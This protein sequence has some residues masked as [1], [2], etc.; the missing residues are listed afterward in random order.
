MSTRR[1][2]GH[3]TSTSSG[4]PSAAGFCWH[5]G[6]K[7]QEL[8]PGGGAVLTLQSRLHC[9]VSMSSMHGLTR[10]AGN[11][12]NSAETQTRKPSHKRGPRKL[13]LRADS[14][15]SKSEAPIGS[16]KPPLVPDGGSDRWGRASP[17]LAS[18][19]PCEPHGALPSA[20]AE[21]ASR[22][23]G[24]RLL[25]SRAP[26]LALPHEWGRVQKYLLQK[27]FV[28]PNSLPPL[29][30]AGLG[31]GAREPHPCEPLDQSERIRA[32]RG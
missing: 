9:P 18:P 24:L 29:V 27:R 17:T 21:G 23:R 5:A 11:A 14:A 26:T 16:R 12:R 30:G 28:A 22:R 13:S 7:T 20:C 2:S 10:D 6:R 25:G 3:A 1:R 19:H 4:E 32:R 31:V 15:G 8:V